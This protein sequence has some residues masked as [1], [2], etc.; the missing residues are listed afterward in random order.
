LDERVVKY[1]WYIADASILKTEQHFV[2]TVSLVNLAVFQ[3]INKNLM[4]VDEDRIK[5]N[6]GIN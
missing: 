4:P 5:V 2:F 6:I 3:P 1:K